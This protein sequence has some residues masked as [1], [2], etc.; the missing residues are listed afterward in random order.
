MNKRKILCID[1]DEAV[2]RLI[3]LV[4]ERMGEYE[5]ATLSDSQLAM[6]TIHQFKPEMIFID[7]NMPGREG[8]EI[9]ADIRA[10]RNFSTVPIIFLTGAVSNEE[11]ERSDGK[12]G[13]QLFLAKPI[14]MERLVGYIK[15][16][17]G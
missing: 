10:E 5:V 6:Q 16:H 15:Q 3:R 7:I 8:S 17:L 14:D 4:L 13:G 9:A 11:I 12:I 2:L 1:D